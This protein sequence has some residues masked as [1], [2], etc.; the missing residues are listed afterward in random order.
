MRILIDSTQIPLS[1]TG[2]GLY[3]E[4]L[5]QEMPA[6]F[7]P[8]DRLFVLVQSD[9]RAF[10]E[11]ADTH[12]NLTPLVLPSS[13]F[14][15]RI[16]LT[17]YEQAILPFIALRRRIDVIHSLHYTFP[18]LC[19]CPRVVTLHDMTHPL[20][21]EMHTFGHRTVMSAFDRL[22]MRHAEAVL[23][24][25]E[26]TR[27]DAERLFGAG[28]NLREVTPLGVDHATFEGISRGTIAETLSRL[29]IAEPYILFLGTLEPR[30]NIPR[31][32]A[33]FDSIAERHPNH[34]LVVAGKPGW[35]YAPALE[36][37]DR[38]PHKD[39]IHRIGFVDPKD[40]P[41]LIAGCE[42]LVYPSLYE[43]FGLPVLEGMAAGAPVIAGNVSSIPE[44]AGEAAALADP[45]SVSELAKALDSVLSDSAYREH[46]RRAGKEQ[47]KK[48]SWKATAQLTYEAYRALADRRKA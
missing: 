36:A 38:S 19:A 15:N 24:V 7:R 43:G 20:F 5:L 13:V 39:R 32:I 47:A 22:A 30:K 1:R 6:V 46:L 48:F 41:A 37:I 14:R 18:L 28:R 2:A 29:G 33:A 10:R 35:H 11:L 31:L 12:E 40:K 16:A 42:A 4:H 9:D 45:Y 44:V 23:F 25:S 34:R 21:P 27:R 26:S 17:F 3:A 8:E